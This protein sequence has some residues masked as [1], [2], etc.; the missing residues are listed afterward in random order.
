M[1]INI[2]REIRPFVMNLEKLFINAGSNTAPDH[3][4]LKWDFMKQTH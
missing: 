1:Q 3:I 4:V 2:K